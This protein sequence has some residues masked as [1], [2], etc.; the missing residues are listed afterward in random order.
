MA[1]ISYHCLFVGLSKFSKANTINNSQCWWLNYLILEILSKLLLIRKIKR[2]TITLPLIVF[3]TSFQVKQ[4]SR[5]DMGKKPFTA[6]SNLFTIFCPQSRM[7]CCNIGYIDTGWSHL[8]RQQHI[9]KMLFFYLKGIQ[10]A[11]IVTLL[12][13]KTVFIITKLVHK[14]MC[15]LAIPHDIWLNPNAYFGRLTI[16]TLTVVGY[17][18]EVES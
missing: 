3:E 8:T 1:E 15:W 4:F 17:I 5:E 9:I 12:F 13:L 2:E 7:K 10:N 11:I 6:Y 16:T 18:S 14:L